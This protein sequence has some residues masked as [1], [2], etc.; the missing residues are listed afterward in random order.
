M[1]FEWMKRLFK[2]DTSLDRQTNRQTDVLIP[3]EIEKD[4]LQLG[5]AAGY[6]GRSIHDIH[7]SLER[8]ETMMPSRDWLLVQF[9]EQ[10]KRHEEGEERR[11]YTLLNALESLRSLSSQA[12]EPLKTELLDKIEEIRSKHIPSKKMIELIQLVKLSGKASFQDLAKKM[13]LSGSGFRTLVK[14]TLERTKEIEKF[15]ID[16]KNKGLRYTSPSVLDVQTDK[17]TQ[18]T[19][20]DIFKIFDKF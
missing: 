4:S 20:A 6:T 5:F 9:E 1:V 15:N 8:I 10:L 16:K 2:K 7:K 17:Q 18:E 11:L 13:D 12:P 19:Q 3:E 14:L